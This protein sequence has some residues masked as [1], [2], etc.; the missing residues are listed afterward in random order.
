MP[1]HNTHTHPTRP[2]MN[3]VIEAMVKRLGDYGVAEESVM[4]IR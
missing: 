4:G 2:G 3:D 1:P